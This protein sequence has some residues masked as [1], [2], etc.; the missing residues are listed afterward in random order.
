LFSTVKKSPQN[1]NEGTHANLH[2][3]GGLETF[4]AIA[5]ETSVGVLTRSVAANYGINEIVINLITNERQFK[6][7]I[8]FNAIFIESVS[9]ITSTIETADTVFASSVFAHVVESGTIVDVIQM[10]AFNRVP[11][12]QKH[13]DIKKG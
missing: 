8:A 5:G 7:T 4:L 3:H 6:F 2:H 11:V 13:C 12:G 10:T 9:L 1:L